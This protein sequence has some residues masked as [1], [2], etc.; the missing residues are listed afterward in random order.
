MAPE[1]IAS[2][3][4]CMVSFPLGYLFIMKYRDRANTKPKKPKM[5]E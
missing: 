2:A 1:W 4:S 5:E 3:I